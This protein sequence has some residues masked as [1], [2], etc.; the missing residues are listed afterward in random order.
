MKAALALLAAILPGLAGAVSLPRDEPVPGGVAVLE[1]PDGGAT[2]PEASFDERRVMVV[3]HADHWYAIVGI[4]LE[5]RP[6][7]H[8][9]TIRAA[10][11]PSWQ[12]GFSVS[13][14]SYPEQSLHI[15]NPRMVNPP[16]AELAR[17]EREQAHLHRVLDGWRP[18]SAPQ[19][20]FLWPAEGPETSGFGLRRVLN[21]E[22]RSPHSGIDIG[23]PA[24]TPLRAPAD[25]IVADVGDYYFCGRTLTLDMGQGLYSVFC[26]LSKIAVHRGARVRRGEVIGTTGASGRVTGPNL[27]WTV[28][29]NGTPVD[30]HAF[31]R[32]ATRPE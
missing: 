31:L 21:G 13:P 15:A 14:R 22:P 23:A 12:L 19:L 4:S 20:V 28:S 5:T 29:L 26:H 16:A 7:K 27:H 18:D 6:G 1:L 11:E 32:N 8:A 3:R 9:L 25:A 10:G 30:P 17:I 2:P 24:G